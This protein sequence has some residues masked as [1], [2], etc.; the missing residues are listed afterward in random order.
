[1]C[2]IVCAMSVKTETYFGVIN[3]IKVSHDHI[4]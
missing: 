2:A 3:G 4:D 1:V